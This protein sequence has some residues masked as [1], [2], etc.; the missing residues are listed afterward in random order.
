MMDTDQAKKEPNVNVSF[1]DKAGTQQI[2]GSSK[3]SQRIA[4]SKQ[5][6]TR[7]PVKSSNMLVFKNFNNIKHVPANLPLNTMESKL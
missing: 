1:I 3:I 2:Q 5:Q 6:K 4:F 7:R